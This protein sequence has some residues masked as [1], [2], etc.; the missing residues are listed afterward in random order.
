MRLAYQQRRSLASKARA[1]WIRRSPSRGGSRQARETHEPG[2]PT[3]GQPGYMNESA[4][5]DYDS[6][7]L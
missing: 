6:C 7:L 5:C 2:G 4:A 1:L 3:H